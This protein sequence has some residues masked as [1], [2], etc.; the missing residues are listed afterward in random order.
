MTTRG[1]TCWSRTPSSPRS[2]PARVRSPTCGSAPTTC[3]ACWPD[4]LATDSG[5]RLHSDD[6]TDRRVV[7]DDADLAR[8][9]YA[10]FGESPDHTEGEQV[11][12]GRGSSH[13]T[14]SSAAS[15]DGPSC[16][17]WRPRTLGR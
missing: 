17:D 14:R 3:A 4:P 16:A 1:G 2:R 15:P 6:R 13:A 7:A 9:A 12:E 11:V 10:A 8:D 5:H